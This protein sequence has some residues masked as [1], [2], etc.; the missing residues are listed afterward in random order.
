MNRI[1][2]PDTAAV[3]DRHPR[4]AGRGVQ[5][6]IQDRPI[7]DRIAAVAHVLG[8]AVGRR[9]RSG[10]EMIAADDDRRLTT[11]RRTRSLIARPKR[12]RSPYPSQKMRAGR[13]WNA[14]R[15]CAMR[16]H[17]HSDGLSANMSSASASVAAMSAAS[18]DNAA[19]RNGPCR[20]RRVAGCTP[21]RSR[22]S[23]TRRHATLVACAR[24]LLP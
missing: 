16:I 1:A 12:A 7:R 6:R 22:E 20:R 18:P 17:R 3:M 4:G 21:A 8:L 5:Q 9:D 13:P 23:Q 11:P 24:M 19:H 15:S 10:V 2:D 14:T